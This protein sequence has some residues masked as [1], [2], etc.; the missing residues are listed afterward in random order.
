M[1]PRVVGPRVETPVVRA[2]A[3]PRESGRITGVLLSTFLF[4]MRDPR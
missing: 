3:G 1:G 4:S 2:A